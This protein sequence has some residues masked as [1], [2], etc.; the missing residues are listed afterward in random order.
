ME[1]KTLK[2][3][4]QK[5]TTEILVAETDSLL[6]N[7]I[8]EWMIRNLGQYL[9]GGTVFFAFNFIQAEEMIRARNFDLALVRWNNG[10]AL[11]TL[12]AVK[13]KS[14]KTKIVIM[15]GG[16]PED[17]T[18]KFPNSDHILSGT[19]GQEDLVKAFHLVGLI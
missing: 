8:R 11:E 19:F 7:L 10:G 6:L 13:S 9:P 3:G 2:T 12:K 14:P 18:A 4:I 15:T 5:S 17:V 1:R 16:H